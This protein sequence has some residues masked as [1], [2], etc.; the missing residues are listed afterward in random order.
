MNKIYLLILSLLSLN[1]ITSCSDWNEDESVTIKVPQDPQYEAYLENIR[2][3]KQTEHSYI[4]AWF[5]NTEKTPASRAHHMS[6]VPDSVDVVI[7]KHPDN[8]ADFEISDIKSLQERKGTRVV[9]EINYNTIEAA[10]KVLVEENGKTGAETPLFSDYLKTST[11]DLL[12]LFAKYNYDGLIVGYSGMSTMGMTDVEK[13]EYLALQKTFLDPI[14]EWT[15]SNDQKLI[16]FFGTPNF[17]EDKG[18]LNKS[19]HI[20]LDTR[21]NES[22]ES[23]TI[24][25]LLS[26]ENGVPTDRFIVTASTVS[27]MADGPSGYYSNGQSAVVEAADWVTISNSTFTKAGLAIDNIQNDYYQTAKVYLNVRRAINTITPA[28]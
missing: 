20:I 15:R 8:L 24:S 22:K 1:L 5:D 6:D 14:S 3:Y 21:M 13:A 25:T 19:K 11:N 4:Y 28:P 27:A 2:A 23:L 18:L 16:S 12:A 7:V 10:Y 9:L 17:L 26:I